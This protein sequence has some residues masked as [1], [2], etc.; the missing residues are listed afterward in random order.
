MVTKRC[1][2]LR[3][4]KRSVTPRLLRWRR[5]NERS[6]RR[7]RK[8]RDYHL[9]PTDSCKPLRVEGYGEAVH[10]VGEHEPEYLLRVAGLREQD[11]NRPDWV[12]GTGTELE[13]MANGGRFQR[14][15][16]APGLRDLAAL[17]REGDDTRDRPGAVGPVSPKACSEV[18]PQ[19][20]PPGRCAWPGGCLIYTRGGKKRASAPLPKKLKRFGLYSG[21]GY[22]ALDV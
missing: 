16:S 19:K 9:F 10:G 6:S 5:R 18:H 17:V 2:A 11:V 15:A 8:R 20:W 13:E 22:A 7:N 1:V 21:N 12:S 14:G 3:G 4:R